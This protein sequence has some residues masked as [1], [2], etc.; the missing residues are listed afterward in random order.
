MLLSQILPLNLTHFSLPLLA[1]SRLKSFRVEMLVAALC[2]LPQD[3]LCFVL[4]QP[5]SPE[6]V[7]TTFLYLTGRMDR[8]LLPCLNIGFCSELHG[9]LTC[10][11][12]AQASPCGHTCTERLLFRFRVLRPYLM[13]ASSPVGDRQEGKEGKLLKRQPLR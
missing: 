10:L 9:N 6:R 13:M 5:C 2:L 7:A 4:K 8:S 11:F 3:T 12:I 1:C